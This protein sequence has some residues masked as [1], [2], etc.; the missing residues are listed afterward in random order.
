MTIST[1]EQNSIRYAIGVDSISYNVW[2]PVAAKTAQKVFLQVNELFKD[3][4]F[5]IICDC[6]S[7]LAVNDVVDNQA[8]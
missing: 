7:K 4:P 1:V 8:L 3:E 6:E 2:Q 5:G